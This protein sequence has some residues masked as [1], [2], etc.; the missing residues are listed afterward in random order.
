MRAFEKVHPQYA[1]IFKTQ[2]T[3]AELG[4]DGI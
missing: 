4:S 2:I 1:E 3:L